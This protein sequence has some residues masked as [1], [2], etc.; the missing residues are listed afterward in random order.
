[1]KV[2]LS[3]IFGMCIHFMR[4]FGTNTTTRLAEFIARKGG[5]RSTATKRNVIRTGSSFPAEQKPSIVDNGLIQITQRV[6]ELTTSAAHLQY[7][8]K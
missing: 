4:A 5:S 2:L 3:V 1:M 7:R 8:P 6:L